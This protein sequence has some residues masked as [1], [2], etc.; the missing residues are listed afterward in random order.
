MSLAQRWMNEAAKRNKVL[1]GTTTATASYYLI[2]ENGLF[3]TK[4][5]QAGMLVINTTDTTRTTIL[6]VVSETHIQL[7][8]DRFVSGDAYEIRYS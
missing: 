1:K 5:A 3:M 4:R 6:S 8:D 2:D 7:A